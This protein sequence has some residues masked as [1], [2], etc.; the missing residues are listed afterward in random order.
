MDKCITAKNG[1]YAL[2]HSPCYGDDDGQN[3]ALFVTVG[4]FSVIKWARF[5]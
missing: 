4:P 3:G 2:T 1:G 5:R